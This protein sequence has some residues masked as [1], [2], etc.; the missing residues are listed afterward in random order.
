L[1]PAALAHSGLPTA[2]RNYC[3]DLARLTGL[4]VNLFC[5]GSFEDCSPE[6]ALSL[7]RI[8]QE[9]LQNVVKHASARNV[10][11]TLS[12]EA[13]EILLVITD[14]GI[15]LPPERQ[16]RNGLGLVSMRERVRL[17]DGKFEIAPRAGGG[18][19]LTVRIPVKSR[20]EQGDQVRAT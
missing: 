5:N 6:I 15:G 3:D 9:A 1:H 10:E 18:T 7:Y 13:E 14:D 11:I 12:N 19:R 20:V 2:L 8:T 16:R 17:V 4:A